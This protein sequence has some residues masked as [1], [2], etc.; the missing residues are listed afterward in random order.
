[1][2]LKTKKSHITNLK[3]LIVTHHV[4]VYALIYLFVYYLSAHTHTHTC[5]LLSLCADFSSFVQVC[6]QFNQKPF[7]SRPNPHLNRSLGN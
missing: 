2:H 5:L 1:M 4:C 6:F 7:H 3:K